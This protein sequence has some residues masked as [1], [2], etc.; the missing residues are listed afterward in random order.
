MIEV[1][2]I[3]TCRHCKKRQFALGT[4]SGQYYKG[5]QS[6]AGQLEMSSLSLKVFIF[7]QNCK[8]IK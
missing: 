1:Y 8:Y 7:A 6:E 2:K 4:A 3:L 5:E